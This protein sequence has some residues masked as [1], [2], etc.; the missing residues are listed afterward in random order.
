[1]DAFS[2]RFNIDEFEKTDMKGPTPNSNWVIPGKLIAGAYPGSSE[3]ES[4]HRETITSILDAG[5][6]V[7]YMCA[8]GYISICLLLIHM[9]VGVTTIVCLMSE[10]DL[11]R[12][13]PY[14]G[15]ASQYMME[16]KRSVEFLSFPIPGRLYWVLHVEIMFDQK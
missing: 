15:I 1:M 6:H 4:K 8:C 2:A 3:S 10:K 12:F 7:V 14:K 11:A 9:F 5:V 13:V 16:E